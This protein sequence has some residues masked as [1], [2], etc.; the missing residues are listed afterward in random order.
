MLWIII[1]VI[2]PISAVPKK[3]RSH[4]KAPK[5]IGSLTQK[6]PIPK[7]AAPQA[8]EQLILNADF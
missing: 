8:K 1:P 6:S 7:K 2:G 4:K 5:F 3:K